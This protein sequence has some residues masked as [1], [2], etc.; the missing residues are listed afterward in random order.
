MHTPLISAAA[1]CAVVFTAGCAPSQPDLVAEPIESDAE[2]EGYCRK[3][4]AGVTIRVKNASNAAFNQETTT[5]VIFSPGGPRNVQTSPMAPGE[6]RDVTVDLPAECFVPDCN[7]A[8]TVDADEEVEESNEA[9][10]TVSGV[11]ST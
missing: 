5:M 6:F 1:V 11:C 3:S 10:N 8:I 2:P 7:F 4:G 9:N